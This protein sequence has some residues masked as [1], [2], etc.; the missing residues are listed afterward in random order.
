MQLARFLKSTSSDWHFWASHFCGV[1]TG[2]AA[3]NGS[4][5]TRSAAADA[6]QA[7]QEAWRLLTEQHDDMI[8]DVLAH[9]PVNLAALPLERKLAQLPT[10][11]H[12][13]AC[14]SCCT[15]HDGSTHLTLDLSRPAPCKVALEHLASLQQCRSITLSTEAAS[16]DGDEQLCSSIGALLARCTHIR[17]VRLLGVW[18][19]EAACGLLRH[20]SHLTELQ[21]IRP[22][23]EHQHRQAHAHDRCN[24]TKA[25]RFVPQL[26]RLGMT[27]T[28]TSADAHIFKSLTALT[29]LT[30]LTLVEVALSDVHHLLSKVSRAQCK[31]AELSLRTTRFLSRRVTKVLH[32]MP[33]LTK[34]AL[35]DV[36]ASDVHDIKR[37]ATVSTLQMLVLPGQIL[38]PEFVA[39]VH[40]VM[41]RPRIQ[42]CAQQMECNAAGMAAAMSWCSG[43]TSLVVNGRDASRP[44][45]AERN[46]DEF[47]LL[48]LEDFEAMPDTACSIVG[49][50]L[51]G[52]SQLTSLHLRRSVWEL[53]LQG[54]EALAQHVAQLKQLQHC[55]IPVGTTG[56]PGGCSGLLLDAFLTTRAEA[57]AQPTR[58]VAAHSS[59][60][61]QAAAQSSPQLRVLS[62]ESLEGLQCSDAQIAQLQ[63]LTCLSVEDKLGPGRAEV[64]VLLPVLTALRK[65]SVQGARRSLL[66][67]AC[68]GRLEQLTSLS[69]FDS[70]VPGKALAKVMSCWSRLVQLDLS[71]CEIWLSEGPWLHELRNLSRLTSLDLTAAWVEPKRAAQAGAEL[72]AMPQLRRLNLAFVLSE[73]NVACALVPTLAEA[74]KLVHLNLSDMDF[75]DAC[76][77]LVAGAFHGKQL[78]ALDMYCNRDEEGEGLPGARAADALKFML[79]GVK[80]II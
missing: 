48:T 33:S 46:A 40:G 17:S 24:V 74:P 50:A 8:A 12:K 23:H 71:Y 62:I 20:L 72:A 38:Q 43:L 30:A 41:A 21:A 35:S 55:S 63:A 19:E 36:H 68:L 61:R 37:I 70:E 9:H 64:A 7:S 79:P 65:L 52:A 47:L 31:L 4:T 22:E 2:K 29:A 13:A 57:S 67:P 11:A 42:L 25:L 75:D 26:R 60:A 39:A 6:G 77:R 14:A 18:P 73:K 27:C 59:I 5:H 51:A 3:H 15:A 10:L 44:R 58:Q 78:T 49:R 76:I 56:A 45:P 69:L 28:L 54:A 80:V 16:N 53:G 32:E 34:L 66:Q 1:L